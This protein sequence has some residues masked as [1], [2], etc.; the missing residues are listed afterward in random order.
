MHDSLTNFDDAKLAEALAGAGRN[1][2]LRE[3]IL[4]AL[5]NAESQ[6]D[7]ADIFRNE[8]RLP[9]IRSLLRDVQ[10]HRV[11][12]QNGLIFEVGVD[13][14]IEEALLLSSSANPD[15]VWEPQTTK[16]LVSLA[17]DT[18]H[19]IVG[20][21]YI[22]DQVLPIARA[23]MERNHGGMVHAFEPMEHAFIRL[24]HHLKINGIINVSAHQLALWNK[25]NVTLGVEGASALATC[26]PVNGGE[27]HPMAIAQS[28]TID[29]YV[30]LRSVLCVG[31]IMVDLEGGEEEA[32]VGASKTLSRPF[33]EAPHLVFEVHRNYV[34]WSS[35]LGNTSIVDLVRS[36]GYT[37]YAIRDF[38]TNY[39]MAGKA[40]EIIPIDRVYLEGPP[41]GFNLLATKDPDLVRRLG[42]RV[43]ENVSPKLLVYKNPAL[44]HPLDGLP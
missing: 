38:Q 20:G 16:L 17:D 37:I 10:T 43:V 18:Q 23:M 12:L 44:H 14:R 39:S 9:V 36:S 28:I 8:V 32:L 1:E 13:S 2:Q 40:I 33:P 30:D 21:A 31:L 5:R 29:D 22:G 24:L 7:N 42:L 41:H 19:V 27:N 15:H 35:G 34:D 11:V 3:I 25:S 6:A 4:E 26:L